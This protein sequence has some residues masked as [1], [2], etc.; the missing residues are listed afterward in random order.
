MCGFEGYDMML[1]TYLDER[2]RVKY[3]KKVVFYILRRRVLNSCI[4]YKKKILKL[5]KVTS[6]VH[7]N[8]NR[9]TTRLVG[10]KAFSKIVSKGVGLGIEKL[11]W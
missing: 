2:G 9:Y 4:I 3:W 11:F 10:R 1:Y 7:I 6:Q 5:E 8:N